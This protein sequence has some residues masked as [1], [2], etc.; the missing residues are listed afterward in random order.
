M[1]VPS[2]FLSKL[3]RLDPYLTQVRCKLNSVN[4]FRSG[5]THIFSHFLVI[6]LSCT[7]WKQV[8]CKS[9][10]SILLLL[11]VSIVFIHPARPLKPSGLL[12][13]ICCFIQRVQLFSFCHT[14]FVYD[15]TFFFSS[16]CDLPHY[17]LLTFLSC[18]FM[19]SCLLSELRIGWYPRRKACGFLVRTTIILFLCPKEAPSWWLSFFFL[20]LID[21]QDCG[22]LEF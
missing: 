18:L 1:W 7:F 19:F 11:N 4:L 6:F 8:P 14:V 3:F 12:L 2:C 20:L 17:F 13:F 5:Y 9:S 21:F 10:R 15:L 22:G 16:N